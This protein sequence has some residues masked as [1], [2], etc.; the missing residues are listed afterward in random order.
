MGGFLF[1][2]EICRL[3]KVT[4]YPFASMVDLETLSSAIE[5]FSI[6]TIICLPSFADKL[7]TIS[8][9][10]KLKT[11]KN[12]FYLGE[13]F[14]AESVSKIKDIILELDI[15]PLSFTTQETGPIGFQCSKIDG[16]I[17][18]LYD[19]IQ[20]KSNPENDELIVSVFYPE[21]APLLEHA[22]GDIGSYCI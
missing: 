6:D 19:H 14:Q 5:E 17:Y 8:R 1:S 9:K 22:T 15:K 11:L 3:L 21:D 4:Y 10:Q 7:I 18:H 2:H 20:V 16:D 12:L 13:A